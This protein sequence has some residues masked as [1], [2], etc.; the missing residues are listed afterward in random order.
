MNAS[1]FVAMVEL[2]DGARTLEDAYLELTK[3]DM[4]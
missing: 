2:T 1:D 3:G 4:T